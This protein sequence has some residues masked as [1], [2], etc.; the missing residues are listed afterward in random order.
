MAAAKA[1][2]EVAQ[3]VERNNRIGNLITD[4]AFNLW[5]DG[6]VGAYVRYVVDGRD[7]DFIRRQRLGRGKCGWA[8]MYMFAPECGKENA[9]AEKLKG[10]GEG[11]AGGGGAVRVVSIAERC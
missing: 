10:E 7:L 6:K 3:L 1:A 8:G 4:E 2:T 9:K 11:C 5:T